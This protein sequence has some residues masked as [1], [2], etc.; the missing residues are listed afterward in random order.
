MT[1]TF[2]Y[3]IVGAGSAGCVL[4]NRLTDDPGSTVCLLEAGGPDVH[5]YI[6]IPAAVLD[7]MHT[8]SLTWVYHSEPERFAGGRVVKQPRGKIL[9]GSSS[10]N[11]MMYM[12]G[13][14]LDYENWVAMG[15]QGWSYSEVLP[16]F[17]KSETLNVGGDDY[18]GD[19]GPLRVERGKQHNSMFGAFIEAGQ[20][21]G[22]LLTQDSNGYQQEGF[23]PA[24]MTIDQGYRSS[25]SRA[26]LDP[27]KNRSNLAILTHSEVYKLEVK[28]GRVWGVTYQQDGEVRQVAARKE[29]LIAA[30]AINSPK[31]LLLSGIG[32][33]KELHRHGIS[34]TT[35]LEGVG[36]NLMDHI[37]VYIQHE[38]EQPISLQPVLSRMGRFQAGVKWLLTRGGHAA[39]THFEAVGFVRSAAGVEWPDI[40]M[41][42]FPM[43]VMSDETVADVAHGFSNH[44]GHLRPKSRGQ[45]RLSSCEPRDF[46][47]L[48]FNYLGH[49]DDILGMRSAVRLAREV[50]H[51]PAMDSF[52]GRE[53][54]P[55]VDVVTDDEID[56]FVR[57][58][59][60]SNYHA[61]GTCRM[62]Q[63][64]D[65]VV[66]HECRVH[67]LEGVRVVDAS[68]MPQIVSGN[69]NAPTIMIAEKVADHIKGRGMLKS[70]IPFFRN[71]IWREM[72]R[73]REMI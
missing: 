40:Q 49:H 23:G 54:E 63:G 57:R 1:A 41:D 2:D 33:P 42:F 28:E 11:A 50:H 62:G 14:A 13:H 61:S 7:V 19:H 64:P 29:V 35:A 31:L 71:P 21:A 32:S 25:T 3:V 58:S 67:N 37:C 47:K 15:A 65:A 10:I 69:T 5:P 34:V 17:R 27:I 73:N 60:S 12:R 48:V 36:K 38:C 43:A 55:G 18:R 20:Q 56:D 70:E 4:A 6:K 68:V 51:Q 53:I 8:E 72:Q 44:V 52:R 45:V 59:I 24:D 9:G 66:D 30:G 16:Y 39:T 22:Y 46:P 26:Y